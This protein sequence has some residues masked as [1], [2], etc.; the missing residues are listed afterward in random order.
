MATVHMGT[1]R[2]RSGTHAKVLTQHRPSASGPS[3]DRRRS[4]R[5]EVPAQ[6][7]LWR[8]GNFAGRYLLEDLSIGGCRLIDGPPHTPGLEVEVLIRIPHHGALSLPATVMRKLPAAAGRNSLGL[9]F[10]ERSATAEDWI[11][12]VVLWAL[13]GALPGKRRMT[14]V[15]TD[16]PTMSSRLVQ[17]LRQMGRPAIAAHTPLDAVQLMVEQG[18]RVD[19]VMLDE[20]LGGG[21]GL[22]LAQFLR[23]NHPA[24]HRIVLGSRERIRALIDAHNCGVAEGILTLP[25]GPREVEKLLHSLGC[26]MPIEP[27]DRACS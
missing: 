26:W 22:E 24:V 12:D 15:L 1:S 11:H 4:F 6:A 25:T 23:H 17:Q 7:L 21:R 20:R 27:R 19:V 16:S 5:V 9:Q 2:R 18:D 8:K 13:E 3:L 10:A 14:L